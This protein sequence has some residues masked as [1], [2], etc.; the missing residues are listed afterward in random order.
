MPSMTR[1]DFHKLFK[2][3]GPV[4]LPVIH[5]TDNDQAARNVAITIEEKPL[6]PRSNWAVTGL[7][8]YDSHVVDIAADLKPSARGELEI[9]DVNRAYLERGELWVE[10]LDRGFAWLDTGTPES[11]LEASSF[12]SVIEKRQGLKISCPEEIAYRMEFITLEQLRGL[13]NTL[14][15]SYGQYLRDLV[16]AE[17]CGKS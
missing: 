4:V 6:Q 1:D 12:V 16:T 11:L 17:E 5:V 3:P 7:Y 10:K 9:T 8:F 13:A 2:S 15:N 14:S